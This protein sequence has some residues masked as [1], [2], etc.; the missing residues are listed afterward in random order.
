M[1]LE[2]GTKNKKNFKC[3]QKRVRFTFFKNLK[4]LGYRYFNINIKTK[5]KKDN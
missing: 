4:K 3:E 5:M 2:D 1:T